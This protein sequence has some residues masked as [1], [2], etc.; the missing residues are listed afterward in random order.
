MTARIL[1]IEDDA[2]SLEL[3]T[4]LLQCAGF[5]TLAAGN[6]ID[7]LQLALR[8]DP[9][10]IVSDI[11]MPV[12]NGYEL[13][14]RLRATPAWRRVPL[15]ALSAFSMQGDREMA[16]AAGFD[17]YVTKPLDPQRFAGEIAG[18]LPDGMRATTPRQR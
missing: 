4:Y 7:G 13:V 14:A 11:Q 5:A 18:H 6:G 16:L 3:T 9:D 2:A 12:L 1:V 17:D 8:E 15:I 10:L